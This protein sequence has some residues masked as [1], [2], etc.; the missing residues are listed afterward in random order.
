[1]AAKCP[2][3]NR[4]GR[5]IDFNE[6][7]CRCGISWVEPTRNGSLLPNRPGWFTR[8]RHN[9]KK[10]LIMSI[11]LFLV[12]MGVAMAMKPIMLVV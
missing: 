3:C 4:Q 5:E 6:Y 12:S 7:Q 1:M 8:N 10:L 2:A 11:F 9:L